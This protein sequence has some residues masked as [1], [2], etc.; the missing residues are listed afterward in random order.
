MSKIF[1]VILLSLSFS[2]ALVTPFTF[3][4]NTQAATSATLD[5]ADSYSVIADSVTCTGAS[6]VEFNVGASPGSSI[7]GFPVPCVV[8]PPGT[9][10]S[11]DASSVAAQAENTAAFTFIDQ[12]CDVTYA[13]VQD[14]TLV[15]PLVAGT[16]CAT[17]SFI[18]TGNL[19]LEGSGVWIFK[20]PST[21][22]TSPGS[23][24]TGGDA[25]DVWWR[26]GS[27]VTLDT[28]TSFIG[29]VLA[30]TSITMSN[31]ATLDGRLMAQTAA[32]TL[33]NN[34]ITTDSCIAAVPPPP[35][36]EPTPEP[37]PEPEEE[38]VEVDAVT[39]PGFPSTGTKSD[40]NS[41]LA[42]ILIGEG[43]IMS[44]LIVFVFKKKRKV[45]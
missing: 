42:T 20:S 44:A 33:D 31:G 36:E 9:T 17:G 39:T 12:T 15:S 5:E 25:C 21:I 34:V 28:T 8:G 14:L 10:H 4:I 43:I 30:L 45:T 2:I 35:V 32:I 22:I 24:V 26:A 3:T 1:R 38:G 40:S 37:E 18:L 13:G 6:T 11:A 29:N 19:T 7:T 16:Y 41:N 23:S 27:S